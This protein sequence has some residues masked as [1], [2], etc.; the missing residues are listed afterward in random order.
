MLLATASAFEQVEPA[1]ENAARLAGAGRLRTWRSMTWPLVRPAAARAAALVFPLAL[2]EPGAPLILG[3]RRTLAFQIV[4]TAA[5]PEP[6]PRLAVWSVMAACI[7]L[8]AR[9]VLRGWGGPDLLSQASAMK[10]GGR[11]RRPAS[12]T[13]SL[14]DLAGSAALAALVV[15]GWL[16]LLGLARTVTKTGSS[17]VESAGV[18]PRTIADISRAALAPPVPQLAVNSLRIGLE[19]AAAVWVLGWLIRPDS[20]VRRVPGGGWR[21]LRPLT[22]IPPLVLGAGILALPLIARLFSEFLKNVPGC[23]I[24]GATLANLARHVD[25]ERNPGILLAVAVVISVAFRVLPIGNDRTEHQPKGNRSGHDAAVLAGC[26]RLRARAI[27]AQRSAQGISG[28]LVAAGLA[29]T[30]LAPA[31]LFTP[32]MDGRTIAPGLVVLADSPG[33]GRPQAAA[34]ALGVIAVNAAT[35]V[36]AR[37]APTPPT[38]WDPHPS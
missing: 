38:E 18:A 12:R 33:V 8:A 14:I 22:T 9:L 27:A 30:N 37:F 6:F 28:F 34:L 20:A 23:E 24:A 36:A 4:E 32:W 3:L 2:V 16:P 7:S 21:F 11:T 10:N 13:I 17:S 31:L 35:L 29:A 5:R 19:V 15:V 1:W 25:I 26:S